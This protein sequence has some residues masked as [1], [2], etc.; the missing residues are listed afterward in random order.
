[1][2]VNFRDDESRQEWV[3][4]HDECRDR[5]IQRELRKEQRKVPTQPGTYLIRA[6]NGGSVFFQAV[7]QNGE[8]RFIFDTVGLL[9]YADKSAEWTGPVPIS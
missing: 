7:E 8:L 4:F 9:Q 1:M 2:Q 6:G 3:R 5:A